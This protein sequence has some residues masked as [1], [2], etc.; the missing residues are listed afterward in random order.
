MKSISIATAVALTA[1]H[2]AGAANLALTGTAFQSTTGF[3]GVASRA[4]DG[5]R[6]GVYGGN[7][8]THTNNGANDFWQ[9]DFGAT[10]HLSTINLWNRTDCCANRL[11]NFSIQVFDAASSLVFEQV[12]PLGGSGQFNPAQSFAFRSGRRGG[13]FA[14]SEMVPTAGN[15]Y[16]SLAE[17]EVFGSQFGPNAARLGIAALSST[18]SGGTAD[19][20]NDGIANP[21]FF[22]QGSVFHSGSESNPW[23]EV[24]LP[25]SQAIWEVTAV[26]RADGGAQYAVGRCPSRCVFGSQSGL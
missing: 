10:R 2:F 14:S 12:I 9:V 25:V 18:G 3:G 16:I 6:N 13:S 15:N 23:W 11:D 1:A 17:V 4:V 24:Q 7:S 26:N 8:V 22:D 5:N 21:D 19:R 20:G